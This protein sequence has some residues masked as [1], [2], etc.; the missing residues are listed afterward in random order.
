MTLQRREGSVVDPPTFLGPMSA[1]D[2][3]KLPKRER[4]EIV[5]PYLREHDAQPSRGLGGRPSDPGY[6]IRESSFSKSRWNW[7]YEA[8]R[9]RGG[10]S[11]DLGQARREIQNEDEYGHYWSP[12]WGTVRVVQ[13][14]WW[15]YEAEIN[16]P[17]AIRRG[18]DKYVRSNES[19]FHTRWA[20]E[21]WLR[22][23]KRRYAR[24]VLRL[25]AEGVYDD[26]G[27]ER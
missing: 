15:R 12:A 23:K 18:E 8:L 25:I 14:G 5:K 2:A 6:E 20:A 9:E 3:A 22:R 16:Y 11:G 26:Y 4:L 27:Y 10:S 1:K 7:I 24:Y 19:V 21:R 17:R 13:N